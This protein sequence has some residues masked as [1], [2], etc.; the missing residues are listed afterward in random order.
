MNTNFIRSITIPIDSKSHIK[1]IY[2]YWEQAQIWSRKIDGAYSGNLIFEGFGNT[3]FFDCE[4]LFWFP[5]QVIVSGIK[6]DGTNQFMI[7]GTTATNDQHANISMV[8]YDNTGSS[9]TL[10]GNTSI[11]IR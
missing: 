7:N 3:T 9:E 11:N 4:M 1:A 8:Q 5:K 10:Q 6:G 2:S